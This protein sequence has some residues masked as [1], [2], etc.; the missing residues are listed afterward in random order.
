MWTK[1]VLSACARSFQEKYISKYIS[2]L[3]HVFTIKYLLA[4][5]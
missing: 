2:N 1:L 4:F 5:M 3:L